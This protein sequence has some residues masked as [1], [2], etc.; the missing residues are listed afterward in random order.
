MFVLSHQLTTVALSIMAVVLSSMTAIPMAVRA[1]NTRGR[2]RQIW[3]MASAFALGIGIWSM[4]FIGVLA[5]RY[6]LD[7][8]FNTG[9]TVLSL[10]PAM[11]ASIGLLTVAFRRE[12]GV[13][14]ALGA[15]AITAVGIVVMH[16]TGMLALEV[17]VPP[18]YTLRSVWSAFAVAYGASLIGFY[19]LRRTALNPRELSSKAVAAAGLAFGLAA[20]GMHYVAMSG[21][22]FDG[23]SV[24]LTARVEIPETSLLGITGQFAWLAVVLFLMLAI[25]NVSGLLVSIYDARLED[26]NR[27]RALELESLNA[28]L[29]ERAARLARELARE[30][31]V[32]EAAVEAT[33]DCIFSYEPQKQKL[34]L[35]GYA[36][37]MFGLGPADTIQTLDDLV[38]RVPM[39]QRASF[40]EALTLAANDAQA[41]LAVEVNLADEGQKDRW[42]LF[43]GRRVINPDEGTGVL[44]GAI[45]DISAQKVAAEEARAL[46]N[47]QREVASLRSQVI[48]ILSHELRTPLAVLTTGSDLLRSATRPTERSTQDKVDGYFGT[49]E[50]A[51]EKVKD[52]LQEAL[53][54]NRLESGEFN[55]RPERVA[56]R[57][58]VADLARWACQGQGVPTDRVQLQP[59]GDW[60]HATL[61]SGLF[62][63]ALRNLL[64]NGLKYSDGKAVVVRMARVRSPHGAEQ[65]EIE[66]QDQGIGIPDEL[67]DHLF[68]P[69]SRGQNVGTRPGT[70]LGLSIAQRAAQANN[71]SLDLVRSSAEGSVFRFTVPS[72]PQI[73]NDKH[74][75]SPSPAHEQAPIN[76]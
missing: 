63:Q 22:D 32:F 28:E 23:V 15:P 65:I 19:A 41:S 30:K 20:S 69:F 48:R 8:D 76:L 74:G 26:E 16:Y 54:Y 34:F 1:G 44:V 17:P 61:D 47:R 7:I 53:A 58:I 51:I 12:V 14:T 71:G 55:A 24:C 73:P 45:S 60:G 25:V 5:L 39:A 38:Q 33:R 9:L 59:A 43:R 50:Q 29:D 66:V 2:S 57:P 21:T 42:V 56:L 46:A 10:L 11:A 36:R 70:G 52:I 75:T 37:I 31:S 18:T 3:A 35:S 68:E 64:V 4:H 62:D 13:A 40:R 67:R 27:R 72:E 6:P 49:M